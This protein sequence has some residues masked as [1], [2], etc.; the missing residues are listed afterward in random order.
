[1]DDTPVLFDGLLTTGSALG[2]T[3]NTPTGLHF[4]YSVGEFTAGTAAMGMYSISLPFITA[5]H[6]LAIPKRAKDVFSFINRPASLEPVELEGDYD[7][8]FS[9]YAGQH[10]QIG[11]RVLLDPATMEFSIEFCARYAWEI[12]NE[13]LY[14]LSSESLPD[15][16]IV[17]NFVA[18]LTPAV[19]RT[20]NT[21]TPLANRPQT[22][23]KLSPNATKLTC[24]VCATALHSGKHWLGCPEGHGYLITASDIAK[25]RQHMN[26][27]GKA[28][29]AT[30]GAEPKVITKIS[31][32]PHGD[33]KCPND[34]GPLLKTTYQETS[35]YLYICHSCIYRWIDGQDLDAIL[36]KYRND[37]EDQIDHDTHLLPSDNPINRFETYHV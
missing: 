35:A 30:L 19:T 37:S 34:G 22:F 10:Q 4:V 25:T 12:V 31:I 26:D 24:P 1:M 36:G 15:L 23:E 32:T 16:H 18:M 8:Y 14:F 21:N 5:T 3:G 28:M 11:S 20:I 13:T 9:L 29:E 33:L 6:L 27:M 17:D 2:A 7:S